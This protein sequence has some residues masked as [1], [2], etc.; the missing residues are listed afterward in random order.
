MDT[1][2]IVSSCYTRETNGIKENVVG[3]GRH[4]FRT[5]ISKTRTV[6]PEL[7]VV[8]VRLLCHLY[9]RTDL[10]NNVVYVKVVSAD[11]YYMGLLFF[12]VLLVRPNLIA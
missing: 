3:V 4:C 5:S 6:L 8:H 9:S 7:F 12:F 11:G 1:K 10:L 2:T